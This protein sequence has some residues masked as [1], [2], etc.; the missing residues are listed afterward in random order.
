MSAQSTAQRL[1]SCENVLVSK[2]KHGWPTAGIEDRPAPITILSELVP[3]D[4][5]TGTYRPRL[6]RQMS[7]NHCGSVESEIAMSRKPS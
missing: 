7:Q 2:K 6:T 1:D 4:G 3:I 5:L